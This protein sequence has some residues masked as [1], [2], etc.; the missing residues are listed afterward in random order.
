MT[1][2]FNKDKPLSTITVNKLYPDSNMP[3]L[4]N[5]EALMFIGN[6]KRLRILKSFETICLDETVPAL[7][8]GFMCALG[9]CGKTRFNPSRIKTYVREYDHNPPSN[10]LEGQGMQSGS[11]VDIMGNYQLIEDVIRVEAVAKGTVT[12]PPAVVRK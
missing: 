11:H 4:S 7:S 6:C 12:V 9:W 10:F 2:A 3:T 8:G 5:K 1:L